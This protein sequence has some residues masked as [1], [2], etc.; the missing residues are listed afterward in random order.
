[1]FE[2]DNNFIAFDD[3][4]EDL[5]EVLKRFGIQERIDSVKDPDERK[6]IE[7]KLVEHLRKSLDQIQGLPIN[8]G[9]GQP[10]A[11]IKGKYFNLRKIMFSVLEVGANVLVVALIPPVGAALTAVTLLPSA[12]STISKLDELASNLTDSELAVYKAIKELS[13]EEKK[14][15]R[16]FEEKGISAAEI[17]NYY[18]ARSQEIKGLEKALEMLV[19]KGVLEERVGADKATSYYTIKRF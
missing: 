12:I 18:L 17:E 9:E 1:M 15:G 4:D 8:T 19:K 7:K 16:I 6:T 5:V 10:S 11:V 13:G 14:K 2:E 3:T